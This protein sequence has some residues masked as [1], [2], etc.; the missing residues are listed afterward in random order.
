VLTAAAGFLGGPIAD[1]GSPA[2]APRRTV[3]T[4]IDPGVYLA[5]GSSTTKATRFHDV[6]PWAVKLE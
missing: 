1:A 5:W 3:L 6:V 4:E 2:G